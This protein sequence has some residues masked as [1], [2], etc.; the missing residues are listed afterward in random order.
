MQ[1]V[2]KRFPP[3]L[4]SEVDAIIRLRE[5]WLKLNR[6]QSHL[7]SSSSKVTSVKLEKKKNKTQ[8]AILDRFFPCSM[9]NEFFC[10]RNGTMTNCGG[11]QVN[12]AEWGRF[13]CPRKLFGYQTLY[14]ITSKKYYTDL[15]T[16]MAR[17]SESRMSIRCLYS[18]TIWPLA[19]TFFPRRNAPDDDNWGRLINSYRNWDDGSAITTYQLHSQ[20]L[21]F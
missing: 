21:P 19:I 6:E 8:M 18:I 3:V 20:T 5:H 10:V 12:T 17:V 2:T 7:L 1:V 14:F 13:M 11:T 4:L 9:S 15:H 16:L